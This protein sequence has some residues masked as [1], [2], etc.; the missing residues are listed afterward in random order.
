M[1]SSSTGSPELTVP[2]SSVLAS[3]KDLSGM[4]L[5]FYR[6]SVGSF[7]RHNNIGGYFPRCRLLLQIS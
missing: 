4:I 7:E 6:L 2:P 3:G 1:Y 5:N